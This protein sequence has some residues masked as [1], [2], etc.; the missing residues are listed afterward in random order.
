MTP[1]DQELASNH[2]HEESLDVSELRMRYK[3]YPIVETAVSFFLALISVYQAALNYPFRD[4]N[5]QEIKV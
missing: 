4:L 2:E 5:A 3:N 1:V